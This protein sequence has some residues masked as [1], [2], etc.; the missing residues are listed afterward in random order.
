V[1]REEF[2]R[3]HRT[4]RDESGASAEE[5]HHFFAEGMLLNVGAAMELG[6]HPKEWSLDRLLDDADRTGGAT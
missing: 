2:T 4:V 3:L 5:L 6:G 1:V